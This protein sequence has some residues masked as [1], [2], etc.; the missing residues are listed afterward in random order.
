MEKKLPETPQ[1]E[2]AIVLQHRDQI[3]N[4]EFRREY[5]DAAYHWGIMVNTPYD[6]TC[7]G[8]LYHAKNQRQIDAVTC[9]HLDTM[10]WVFEVRSH[11]MLAYSPRLVAYAVVGHVPKGVH[12]ITIYHMLEAIPLSQDSTGSIQTCFTWVDQAIHSL[13]RAEYIKGFDLAQF[14]SWAMKVA[15]YNFMNGR[16]EKTLRQYHN[17]GSE[18]LRNW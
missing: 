18:R 4:P 7:N 11:F 12:E 2:I 9:Q 5:G 3:S 16:S 8:N 1:L 10:E 6:W 13:Q 15:D 14:K 17:I